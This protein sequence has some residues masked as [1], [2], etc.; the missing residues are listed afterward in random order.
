MSTALPGR[1]PKQAPRMLT[2][3]LAALEQSVAQLSAQPYLRLFSWW[4]L[5]QNWGTLRFSDHR[6][7]PPSE[8]KVSQIGFTARLLR[9]KTTGSDKQVLSRR[10]FISSSCYFTTPDWLKIGWDLLQSL[11]PFDRDCLMPAPSTHYVA[12]KRQELRYD[13]AYALQ[14]ELLAS[15][16]LSGNPLFTKMI[17]P[18]WTPHSGRAFFPSSAAALGIAKEERDF[19]GGWSAQGSDRYARVAQ[20]RITKIQQRV[21]VALQ[22]KTSDP[23][24]KTKPSR[25]SPAFWRIEASLNWTGNQPLSF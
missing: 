20:L 4:V 23:S 3:M 5:L 7:S 21:I 1:P 13:T 6:G 22:S 16:S 18:F 10:V 14:S 8:I 25:N 15:L 19:L 12:C 17:T 24:A 9:S 2:T 11:A